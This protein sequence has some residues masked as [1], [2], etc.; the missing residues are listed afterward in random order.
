MA[1]F[2]RMKINRRRRLFAAEWAPYLPNTQSSKSVRKQK[3]LSKASASGELLLREDALNGS[4]TV[5]AALA[6]SLFLYAASLFFTFFS[7]EAMQVRLQKALDE[8]GETAAVWSYAAAFAEQY[9]GTDLMSFTEGSRFGAAL[10]GEAEAWAGLLDENS[11]LL[12]EAGAFLEEKAA[13]AVWQVLIREWLIARVGRDMLD[14]SAVA[15]G[16]EGLSLS[17]STLRTRDLDLVLSYTVVSPVHFPFTLKIPVVQRSCRR[18]WTGTLTGRTDEAEEAEEETVYLTKRGTVYHRSLACRVLD[19]TVLPV[20]AEDLPEKRNN[21]GGRYYPCEYCAHSK[22]P[23][24]TV[25][26]TPE[27]DR[28][29]EKK[30]CGAIS[31]NIRMIPLSEAEKQYRPCHYCGEEAS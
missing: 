13:A 19:L 3:R 31:R 10:S 1:L 24:G 8:I 7:A 29:H 11:D 25:Y 26:I 27:G 6:F 17:G 30:N 20:N 16:A 5:E 9:T 15:G 28:Y 23:A 18:L 2:P 12:E 21:S 14:R 4:M 22:K